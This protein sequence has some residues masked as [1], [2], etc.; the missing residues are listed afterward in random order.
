MTDK[1]IELDENEKTILETKLQIINENILERPEVTF[2][3]FVSDLKKSG[4]KYETVTGKVKKINYYNNVIILENGPEIYIPDILE[5]DSE[6]GF[7]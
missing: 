7:E 5:M 6:G 3:Y 2:T 4:G 1:K